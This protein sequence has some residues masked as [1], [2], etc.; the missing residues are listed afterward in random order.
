MLS[1]VSQFYIRGLS[2]IEGFVVGR[3]NQHVD[4]VGRFF[5]IHEL[6]MSESPF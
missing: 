1:V 2:D 4:G 3:V 6:N 5:H